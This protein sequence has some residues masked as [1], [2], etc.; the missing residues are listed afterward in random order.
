LNG[1]RILD[2]GCGFGDL[3]E[4]LT[5]RGIRPIYTGLDICEPMIRH[6]R[7]RFAPGGGRFVVGDVLEY[8]PDEAFDFVFASGIFGLETE[9]ARARIR[10]SLERMFSWA[11]V[12]ASANFLSRRSPSPADARVYVEPG[13]ALDI[14][15]ALTPAAR[16]DHSYLPNDFTLHLYKRPAW[17]R[18]KASQP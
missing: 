11:G 3:L 9:D 15:L 18:E 16:L 12:A 8:R 2:V 4:F 13:E 14:G 5:E 1:R 17:E 7:G 10:P 6:C